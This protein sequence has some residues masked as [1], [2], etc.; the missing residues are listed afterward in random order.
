MIE[1]FANTIADKGLMSK[2]YKGIIQFCYNNNK[3]LI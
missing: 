3:T 1:I 2:I